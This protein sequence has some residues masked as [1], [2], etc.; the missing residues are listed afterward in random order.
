MCAQRGN[1]PTDCFILSLKWTRKRDGL[2]TWWGP[3][4][5]GYVFRIDGTRC[6]AGRYTLAEVESNL[7]YYHNGHDTLAVPCDEA[8]NAAIRVENCAS[9][10]IDIDCTNDHVVEVGKLAAMKKAAKAW[11]KP[12]PHETHV[13]AKGKR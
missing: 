1:M 6:P 13:A 11:K 9:K 10:A 5:A 12:V 7:T 8:L 4:R 3:N 2:L